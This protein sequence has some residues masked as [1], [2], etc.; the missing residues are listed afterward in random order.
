MSLS[1]SLSEINIDD[2]LTGK[3]KDATI[4]LIKKIKR[5]DVRL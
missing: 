3:N 4:K 5:S 1:F 2:I